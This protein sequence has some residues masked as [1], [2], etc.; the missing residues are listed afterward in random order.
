MYSGFA[1]SSVS[2]YIPARPFRCFPVAEI[3]GALGCEDAAMAYLL[4]CYIDTMRAFLNRVEA[5]DAVRWP[6]PCMS[7]VERLYTYDE[8]STSPNLWF[9][10]SNVSSTLLKGRTKG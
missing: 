4:P 6:V 2:F 10:R 5:G 1:A 3:V 7:P 9:A 8:H